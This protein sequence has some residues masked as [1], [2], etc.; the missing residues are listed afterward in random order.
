[1]WRDVG[2]VSADI[3][4]A[5][6]QYQMPDRYYYVMGGAQQDM[7]EAFSDLDCSYLALFWFTW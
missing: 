1:V 6:A 2:S 3:A 5:L 4:A 7:T